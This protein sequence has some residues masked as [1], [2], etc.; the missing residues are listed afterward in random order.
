MQ[1]NVFE[2]R[3]IEKDKREKIIRFP[4]NQYIGNVYRSFKWI[5][6]ILLRL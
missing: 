6:E 2:N 3:G 5:R 4:N 1:L